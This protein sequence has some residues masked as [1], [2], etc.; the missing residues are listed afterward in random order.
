MKVEL[1][2]TDYMLNV[3]NNV[4]SIFTCIYTCNCVI[5]IYIYI[6]IYMK[7]FARCAGPKL[8]IRRYEFSML[9]WIAN[10]LIPNGPA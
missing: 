6:Y 1:Q 3:N 5:Y 4:Y 8:R 9:R 10:W 7:G 2:T